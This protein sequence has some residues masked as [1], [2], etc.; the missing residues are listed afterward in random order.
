MVAHSIALSTT[1]GDER[2][3]SH[4]DWVP[5]IPS[6]GLH[7]CASQVQ[8]GVSDHNANWLHLLPHPAQHQPS[9]S[10]FA[11]HWSTQWW[12]HFT[13]FIAGECQSRSEITIRKQCWREQEFAV[14]PVIY[15][16]LYIMLQVPFYH[17]LNLPSWTG[18]LV[19][20]RF[21]F[22]N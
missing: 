12:D 5:P 1:R 21:G 17:W 13:Q 15:L 3:C 9:Q 18:I 14:L 6:N 19:K 4:V 8:T 22:W 11:L 2:V 20:S 10:A 7:H 16:S